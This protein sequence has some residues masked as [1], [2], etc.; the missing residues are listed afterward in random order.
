M[1]GIE[2]PQVM[3]DADDGETVD[4]DSLSNDENSELAPD[5]DSEDDGKVTFDE[6]QQAVF[7][8]EIGKKTEKQR[9]AERR[10]E[11]AEAKL[12]DAQSKIPQEARPTISAVPE[13]FDAMASYA[14]PHW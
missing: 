11:A 5:E 12:A 3:D 1:T 2:A 14:F 9:S 7:N 4:D 13:S 8:R 6:K 10:A